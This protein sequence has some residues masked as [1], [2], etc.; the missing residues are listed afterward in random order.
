[1]GT[2]RQAFIDGSHGGQSNYLP[3][4]SLCWMSFRK[5]C[6]PIARESILLKER[7]TT[8]VII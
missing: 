4:N 7:L 1:M 8:L 3:M 2:V 6:F 5:L